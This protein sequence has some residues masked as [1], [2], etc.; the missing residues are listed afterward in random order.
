MTVF[1][2]QTELRESSTSSEGILRHVQERQHLDVNA[3][4]RKSG[5]FYKMSHLFCGKI[6]DFVQNVGD[7]AV[8]A[9][10]YKVADLRKQLNR[11]KYQTKLKTLKIDH[12]MKDYKKIV[13][14]NAEM[15]Q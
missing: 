3:L 2:Y 13:N 4:K 15:V 8:E 12:L 11:L 9:L 1:L 14:I 6:V 5:K 7:D 10:D